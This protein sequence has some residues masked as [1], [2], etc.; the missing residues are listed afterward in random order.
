MATRNGHEECSLTIVHPT[1]C[2]DGV[3]PD[4]VYKTLF[5][6]QCLVSILSS[7]H[8]EQLIALVD[9][10]RLSNRQ[11]SIRHYLLPIVVMI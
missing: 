6:E 2:L 11:L 5:S 9:S 10:C 3:R 8:T 7:E 1:E 4:D